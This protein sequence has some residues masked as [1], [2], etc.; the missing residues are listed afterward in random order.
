MGKKVLIGFAILIG[1]VVVVAAVALIY[2]KFFIPEPAPEVLPQSDYDITAQKLAEVYKE[3]EVNADQVYKDKVVTITGIVEKLD[4]EDLRGLNI[5]FKLENMPP[6][7]KVKAFFDY[8]VTLEQ[9]K[10]AEGTEAKIKCRCKGK[11]GEINLADCVP[12]DWEVKPAEGEA[13]PAPAQ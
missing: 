12:P 2:L 3:N 13:Q 6:V 9:I 7:L 11:L 1:I 8:R 4:T 5:L 10:L